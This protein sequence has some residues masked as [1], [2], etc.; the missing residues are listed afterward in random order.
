MSLISE[1]RTNGLFLICL[2]CYQSQLLFCVYHLRWDYEYIINDCTL[3]NFV[4]NSEQL[5]IKNIIK[6]KEFMK[7]IFFENLENINENEYQNINNLPSIWIIIFL[8]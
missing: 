8:N 6:N 2:L 3:S 4:L 5:Q 1:N 7:N